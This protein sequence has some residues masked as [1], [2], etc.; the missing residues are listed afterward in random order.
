MTKREEIENLG[1]CLNKA[2]MDEPVF[3]LRAN[4]PE[5]MKTVLNWILSRVENGTNTVADPKIQDA[6]DFILQV[7][8]YRRK[9]GWSI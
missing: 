7:A 2:E 8:I 9:K 6:L 1:S 5:T 3:V 4:D